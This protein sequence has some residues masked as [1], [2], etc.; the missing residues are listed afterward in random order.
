MAQDR[1]ESELLP[2]TH[3]FLATMLGTGRPSASAWQL[4]CWE[5]SQVIHYRYRRGLLRIVNRK[6]LEKFTRECYAIIQQYADG[7]K[8]ASH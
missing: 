2:I 6:K 7:Q 4:R 5:K 1:V 8:R 3:D